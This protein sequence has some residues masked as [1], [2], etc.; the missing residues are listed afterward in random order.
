MEGFLCDCEPAMFC[1][2]HPDKNII[3]Q[4]TIAR[5]TKSTGFGVEREGEALQAHQ[6]NSFSLCECF[7]GEIVDEAH[8]C[9]HKSIVDGYCHAYCHLLSS[10]FVACTSEWLREQLFF[11]FCVLV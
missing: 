6:T 3:P 1:F 11:H 2:G 5:L 10:I 7:D 9:G 8:L 4:P